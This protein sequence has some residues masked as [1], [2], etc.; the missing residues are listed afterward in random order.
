MSLERRVADTAPP[1]P[2]VL[3]DV[4]ERLFA[5]RG[6]ASVSLRSIV[7]ASGQGNLSAA[8]YHFGSREGL[9][10]AVIE[11]RLRTVDALRHRYLDAVV[12]SGR[13]NDV[14]A[15]VAAA[16]EA[17]ADVVR[18]EPWGADYVQVLA[19]AAFDVRMRLFE[20]V[21]PAAQ[22]SIDRAAEMARRALPGL[23]RADFDARVGLIRQQGVYAIARWVATHGPVTPE[24]RRA[25]RAMVRRLVAFMAGGMAAPA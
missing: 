1:T 19:Q 25:Y 16:F 4:A 23:G 10:R 20:T 11:R 8:H 22:S 21:D 13:E 12:A 17:V 14:R 18:H 9:I 3:L 2:T 7:L 6:I 24:N 15:I 5:Q